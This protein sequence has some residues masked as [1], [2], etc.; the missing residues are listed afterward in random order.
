MELCLKSYN[1]QCPKSF[2]IQSHSC[3]GLCDQCGIDLN[4][5]ICQYDTREINPKF[6]MLKS[7]LLED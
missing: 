1:Q 7:L 2:Y 4:K 5:S 3:K 6:E